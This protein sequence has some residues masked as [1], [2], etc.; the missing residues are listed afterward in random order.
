MRSVAKA[1]R[2]ARTAAGSPMT[3]ATMGS[4]C[5][6][7]SERRDRATDLPLIAAGGLMDGRDVAAV[8]AAGAEAAQLGTAFLRSPESGANDTYKAALAD[9][10]FEHDRDHTRVQRSTRTRARESIHAGASECSGR[11]PA[12]QL[13][14]SPASK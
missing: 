2:R 4:V 9:P 5:S 3:N 8:L 10:Q 13:G 12:D 1:S 14:D 11:I 6:H 7:C